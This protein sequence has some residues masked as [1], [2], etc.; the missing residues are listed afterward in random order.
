MNITTNSGGASS[1]PTRGVRFGG[2]SSDEISYITI[3]STGNALD[4]GNLTVARYNAAGASSNTRVCMAAG[5]GT[6][7]TNVID[8]ITTASTGN[9]TDFGDLNNSL[10]GA[11]GTSNGI[12][13]LFAGGEA[14]GNINAIDFI[15]IAS[16]SNATDFGDLTQARNSTSCGSDAHGGIS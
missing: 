7:K 1:S 12:R 11:G 13:G 8:Y 16:A 3:A 14:S 10:Q 4:F 15:T 2:G 5:E 9:A 6:S